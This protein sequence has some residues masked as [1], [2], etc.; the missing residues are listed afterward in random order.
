M[1][2]SHRPR[3]LPYNRYSSFYQERPYRS[4]INQYYLDFAHQVLLQEQ[5]DPYMTKT[6]DHTA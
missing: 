4:F 5:Y 6:P 2:Q 3:I 1:I